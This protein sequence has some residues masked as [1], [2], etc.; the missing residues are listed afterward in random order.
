MA[1]V[2]A[3]HLVQL[4]FPRIRLRLGGLMSTLFD[5]NI[6]KVTYTVTDRQADWV[7]EFGDGVF[8]TVI[9]WLYCHADHPAGG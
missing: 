4:D 6:R 3:L 7:I 5:W 9:V 2:V 1:R 8:W